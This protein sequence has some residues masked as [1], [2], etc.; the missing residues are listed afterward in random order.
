M[1]EKYTQITNSNQTKGFVLKSIV[2][3]KIVIAFLFVLF[4]SSGVFGQVSNYAFS[5]SAGAYSS[6]TGTV[7]HASGW[8]DDVTANTIPI[9]FTFGFN[10]ANYTTCSINSNGF[11]TFGATTS[12][13]ANWAPISS[14][15]AY[16]GAISAIGFDLISNSSTIIYTTTGTAPNRTFIAQW[17]NAQRYSLGAIA[18]DFNFQ[19]RLSETTNVI[20]VVYGSCAPAT[21]TVYSVQV[22]LRGATNAAFNNRNLTTNV[23]WGGN[24]TAGTANNNACN[25]RS[26]AYPQSGRTF[27]WTPPPPP[28]ITSFTPSSACASSSQTVVITGTNFTGATAVTIGGTAAASFVV[29]SATQIT[30]TIG[31]GTTGT[32]QITTPAGSVT[33]VATFTVNPLP[34]AI[35]GGAATVC[36]GAA[37]PAFTNATGGGTW[38]IVSGTGSATIAGSGVV[39]GGTA[40]TVTIVYTLPTTCSI[41]RVIT[42]IAT[43]SITTNPLNST[44]IVGA[45]TSFTVAASNSPTSYTWQ[46]STNGG[47]TWTTVTNGGVYTNATTATLNITGATI[48]MNGYLYRASA[49]NTCGSSSNSS[50]ATLNVEY[51]P[52]TH[53]VSC[54]QSITNVTFN[55]INNTSGCADTDGTSFTNYAIPGTPTTSV[56]IG[57]TYSLSVTTSA[58]SIVSAWIDFNRNGVFEASEWIQVFTAG[59][60]GSVGFLI[61]GTATPGP[62]RMRIRS[63]GVGNTNG[64]ANACTS[65]GGGE[66]ESYLINLVTPVPCTIPTNQPTVL[67]LT[68]SG[69]SITGSFTAP[70]TLP[71]NYL[72]VISTSATAPAAPVNGTTYAIGSSLASGYIVADNDGNTTFTATGLNISTTYYFYIYSYNSFCTGG[73]LYLNTTPLIGNATTTAVVPTYCT[74]S[75][76][77]ASVYISSIRS[78]GTITDVTN[79]PTGYSAGGYGN[80]S[81]TTIATQVAGSGIN[82]EIIVT[83]SYGTGVGCPSSTSQFIKTWVDWNKD[84][85]FDDVGEQHMV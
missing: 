40:G 37:S 75:S 45:N 27:T 48:G 59:T 29:N 10:G 49:T 35:L 41:T 50:N 11:I 51:C 55:T 74:P 58:S 21:T 81:A 82:L 32:I 44:I 57:S 78:V 13:A 56:L 53:T 1:R 16:N 54:V 66:T 85:D 64:S 8:D 63:R 24:T 47:S 9:G 22:G 17:N 34:A 61:P 6:A 68:P 3:C 77:N 43:P 30:A 42:I 65:F 67:S 14:A 7:A 46:V 12:A 31:T 62:T 73:P 19:I 71:N 25:T 39:T 84:G 76:T 18:G 60:T 70:A 72:V 83:G 5:E 52:P 28:T 23:L 80:Y 79:G 2:S 15:T 26:N 36:T 69:T 33:S 38:S 4:G 20:N